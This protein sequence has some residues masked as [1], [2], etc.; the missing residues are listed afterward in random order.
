[1]SAWTYVVLF[2]ASV[3]GGTLNAIVGGGS[4]VA[5]PALVFAHVPAVRAN[6]TTS[7]ALWPG[8][9]ASTVAY[10]KSLTQGR[11]VLI[12]Y[13]MVSLAGGGLGAWLLLHTG[14]RTFVRIVPWLLLFATLVL[15]F[16]SPLA[17]RLSGTAGARPRGALVVGALVQLLIAIY[18]GYFGGGMGILML[19]AWSMLALGDLPAMNGLRSLTAILINGVAVAVFIAARAIAWQPGAVMM[20]GAT[21]AGYAGAAIARRVD[22]A[23]VR[24]VVIVIAWVMTAIFFF[25]S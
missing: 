17:R 21:V 11:A 20:A 19:A 13:S 9:L 15:T 1:M 4:F 5:F 23:K 8:G 14:E 18:G 10:R 24:R 6:A 7:F 2:V 3:V 12:A 16:G 22:A 25:H